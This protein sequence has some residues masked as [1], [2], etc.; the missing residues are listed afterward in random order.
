M[1]ANTSKLPRNKFQ[2]AADRKLTIEL[3]SAGKTYKYIAEHICAIR[4]Y[5]ISAQ[6]LR[7]DVGELQEEL[8]ASAMTHGLEAIA[9]EQDIID[10]LAVE[11]S[12]RIS[13]FPD[14]DPRVAPLLKQ[15][16]SLAARKTHLSGGENYIR[17][18]NLSAAIDR[19]IKAGFKVVDPVSTQIENAIN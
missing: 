8:I 16:E 3:L 17:A 7:V 10:N 14:R 12:R 19:V 4:D 13:T 9:K 2:V 5:T 15:I 6:Q 1:L 11:L 18:Q